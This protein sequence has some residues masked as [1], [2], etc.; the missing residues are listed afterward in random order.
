MDGVDRFGVSM[1]PEL[2]AAFDRLRRQ[3]GYRNRS[4]AIRDIVRNALVEEEWRDADHPVIGTVTL[5]YDHDSHDLAHA[6]MELQ[7]QHHE[8]VVCT[9]HVHMDAHNCLEVVVVRGPAG[10]VREIG[11]RLISTR[12]VKHGRLT[13]STTGRALR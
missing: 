5:V 11:D 3:R 12:G 9:T 2:L 10:V 4:E 8:A 13:C 1:D 6:L 7:H